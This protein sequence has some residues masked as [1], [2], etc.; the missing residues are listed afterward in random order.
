[1]ADSIDYPKLDHLA[2]GGRVSPGAYASI[3][4]PVQEAISRRIEVT[5]LSP[6]PRF[7]CGADCAFGDNGRVEEP[8]K[9]IY[10]VALVWDRDKQCVVD[11]A[12]LVAP[13]EVPYIPTFLSFR[14]G[15]A[16]EAVIG[17]L[18]HPFGAICFDGQ[19]I[20]HPRRCG[21]ASHVGVR[22][23]VPS[24]GIAKSVLCGEFDEPAQRAGATS[25]MIHR[26]EVIGVALRTR[27]GVKPIYVSIG[28]RVDLA[29]A[30]SLALA[31][32]TKFRIPEP[33]R[34]ADIEVAKLKAKS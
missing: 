22:L 29:S 26:G 2:P 8:K 10:A 11:Q 1:M 5:P 27:A 20:A 23:D 19:G 24:V 32:A 33:T 7:V 18:T 4:K 25:P 6:L 13:L 34:L 9:V 14:E 17:K 3:W 31:C 16:L 30:T 28:H 15:P 21:V 12:E